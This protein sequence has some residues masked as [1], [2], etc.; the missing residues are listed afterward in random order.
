MAKREIVFNKTS[1]DISYELLHVGKEHSILFLHG[2]GSNKEI[3]KQAFGKTFEDFEHIYI[4][5]PGFGLSSIKHAIATSEYK[6]IVEEF[7][8]KI[9]KTPDVVV[10]HSFGGKI[11]SL[12]NPKYLVLLSSAGIILPKSI[13]IKTK[14]WIFKTFKPLFPKSFYRFFASKDVAGMSE[15]MYEILK[16]VVNEDFSHIFASLK[17]KVFI[18]WGEQDDATPLL[19]GKKIHELI[20]NSSFC[21]MDGD[22]FFFVK[23]AFE[24]SR[25]IKMEIV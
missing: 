14:I 25:H 6:M 21:K 7:L 20:P 11:A 4:D 5:L 8:K 15:V 12:L 3:M 16:K 19:C 18:F 24:I 2:W 1:Y 22:H 9:E 23:N 13:K 10:G 17:S